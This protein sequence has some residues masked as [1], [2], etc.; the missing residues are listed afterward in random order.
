MMMTAT[1]TIVMTL[2][3]MAMMM[4]T[5]VEP[6]MRFGSTLWWQCIVMV[7]TAWA[8]MEEHKKQKVMKWQ[9]GVGHHGMAESF[10]VELLC[11]AMCCY[12]Q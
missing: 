2:M 7:I 8:K 3:I 10:A 12:V 5:A 1:V 6:T 4:M 11:S 9:C